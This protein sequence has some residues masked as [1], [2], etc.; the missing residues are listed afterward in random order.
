VLP[1]WFGIP[2]SRGF[3]RCQ[4]I[5]SPRG[6]PSCLGTAEPRKRHVELRVHAGELGARASRTAG[7]PA[8][9]GCGDHL[10]GLDGKRH[11]RLRGVR[12]C[13]KVRGCAVEPGRLPAAGNA[14]AAVDLGARA[15]DSVRLASTVPSSAATVSAIERLSASSRS[16]ERLSP[17]R[18][19]AP[20]ITRSGRS[21]SGLMVRCDSGP[22]TRTIACAIQTAVAAPS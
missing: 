12:A 4:A 13:V 5:A 10:F 1:G 19:L 7:S 18:W 16:L 11:R 9:I 21:K 8:G 3:G 17:D 20:S 2:A 15:S 22:R 14:S 6:R